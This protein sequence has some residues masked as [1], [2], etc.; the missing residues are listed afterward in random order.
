MLSYASFV[1]I[2]C[3]YQKLKPKNALHIAYLLELI[4]VQPP[5]A[6]V[7]RVLG[8][9]DWLPDAWLQIQ[10]LKK[11]KKKKGHNIPALPPTLTGKQYISVRQASDVHVSVWVFIPIVAD[12]FII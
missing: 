2:I 1:F 9:M 4:Q 8:A 6:A 10:H 5:Q 11:K 7:E 3:K 12:K